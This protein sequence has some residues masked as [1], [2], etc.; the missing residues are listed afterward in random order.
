MA[1]AIE[2]ISWTS[3]NKVSSAFQVGIL[4]VKGVS[5]RESLG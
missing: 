2:F 5:K 4:I 3:T 1:V